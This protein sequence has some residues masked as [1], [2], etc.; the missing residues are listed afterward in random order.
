MLACNHLRAMPA[1]TLPLHRRYNP[2]SNRYKRAPAPNLKSQI[3][4]F[5]I[6]HPPTLISLD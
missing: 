6:T 3:F 1:V 2:H 4:K 5:E